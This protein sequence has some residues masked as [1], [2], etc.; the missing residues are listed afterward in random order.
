MTIEDGRPSDY[1]TV[2]SDHLSV[3]ALDF[4]GERRELFTQLAREVEYLGNGE[5][6]AY[7]SHLKPE[8]LPLIIEAM[9]ELETSITG[10]VPPRSTFG[11]CGDEGFCR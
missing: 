8:K 4:E 2:L 7:I 9:G 6:D 3:M 5:L 11:I 10:D 1:C